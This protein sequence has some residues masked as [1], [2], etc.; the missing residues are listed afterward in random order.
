MEVIVCRAGPHAEFPRTA[1]DLVNSH[2][3]CHV[4]QFP[5]TINNRR[6]TK[7]GHNPDIRL[8]INVAVP[9]V[10][11]IIPQLP[12]A[13]TVERPRV[14]GQQQARQ[15]IGVCGTHGRSYKQGSDDPSL[16]LDGYQHSMFRWV[17]PRFM[18]HQRDRLLQYNPVIGSLGSKFS[19]MGA[20]LCNNDDRRPTATRAAT[21]LTRHDADCCI[22][23]A[24]RTAAT[25]FP[26]QS[27]W[28][29]RYALDTVYM[30]TEKAD[31][32]IDDSGFRIDFSDENTAWYPVNDDVMGG[33]SRGGFSAS[34]EGMGRFMGQ[35]SMR[36]NG[37]FSS[38]R[39][40][41]TNAALTGYDGVE[42]RVRGDGRMYTLL[43]APGNSRGSWQRNFRSSEDW[44]TIR[45]AFEDMELSVR[46]WRPSSS[47]TLSGGAIGML[48]LLVA[49]KQTRPFS[50][51]IDWIQGF[52]IESAAG[53]SYGPT[54]ESEKR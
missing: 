37:G 51:E 42:M 32:M 34:D 46:G 9:Q 19:D 41:I 17:V 8:G 11:K 15:V 21:E 30:G 35:L 53:Q 50:L 44:Q 13:V 5:V 7:I 18:C 52:V 28:T 48:G 24:L 29:L 43:A 16:M 45:V 3:A 1:Q 14:V 47:P 23:R 12:A 6:R 33:V 25:Q 36:N 20:K 26:G 38:V 31:L 10:L 49:D 40:Q 54:S 39:T 22:W 27:A 4:A 2:S